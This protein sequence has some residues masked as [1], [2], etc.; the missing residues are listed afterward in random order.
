MTWLRKGEWP[1][2]FPPN[3]RAERLKLLEQIEYIRQEVEE[4][5]QALLLGEG[6]DRVIEELWDVVQT[7]E[8]GLR[9][10]PRWRVMVG[11]ARVK[12][13]SLMRGDYG[14]PR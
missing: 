14:R 1:Y 5:R 7:T 6:D 4:A 13:K 9:K 10:F 8:G 2:R 12:L 3:R 11:H